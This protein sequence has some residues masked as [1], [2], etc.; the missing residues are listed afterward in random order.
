[1]K[2]LTKVVLLSFF[3]VAIFLAGPELHPFKSK[4]LPNI[5]SGLSQFRKILERLLLPIGPNEISAS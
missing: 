3:A 2:S 1:M 5:K 4:Q